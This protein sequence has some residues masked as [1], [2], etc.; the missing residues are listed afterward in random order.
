MEDEETGGVQRKWRDESCAPA[1]PQPIGEEHA[2]PLAR[3]HK[4][5][6]RVAGGG[7][8]ASVP[9][10]VIRELTKWFATLESRTGVVPSKWYYIPPIDCSFDIM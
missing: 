10:D 3:T 1:D 7:H 8:G 4:H 6:P 2:Q 9:L 5:R